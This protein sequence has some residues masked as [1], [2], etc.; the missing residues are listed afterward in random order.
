VHRKGLTIIGAQVLTR[1][2]LDNSDGRW[3]AWDENALVLRLIGS[4]RLDTRPLIE[5]EFPASRV[6]DAYRLIEDSPETLGVLLNWQ[7]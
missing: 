3:N 6:A 1:P 4:D 7:K 5:H 2:T